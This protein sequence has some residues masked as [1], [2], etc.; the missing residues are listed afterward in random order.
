[1]RFLRD[2]APARN[3]QSRFSP[4]SLPLFEFADRL[5][6]CRLG[7]AGRYAHRLMPGRPTSTARLIACLAGLKVEE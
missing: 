3:S 1:M 7:I 6:T 2:H 4:S 5:E